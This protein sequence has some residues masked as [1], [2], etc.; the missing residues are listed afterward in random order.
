MH[1]T[2]AEA[3]PLVVEFPTHS[4]PDVRHAVSPALIGQVAPMPIECL[5]SLS[6]DHDSNIVPAVWNAKFRV[7]F[8]SAAG[9]L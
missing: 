4:D 5:V 6:T 2:D 7:A 9:T 3:V 8:L 1:R